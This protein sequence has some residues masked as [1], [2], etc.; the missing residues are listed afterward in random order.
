MKNTKIPTGILACLAL[1]WT[2]C[3]ESSAAE[4][5]VGPDQVRDWK[6]DVTIYDRPG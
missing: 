3:L 1:S 2:L 4:T 5:S 6:W